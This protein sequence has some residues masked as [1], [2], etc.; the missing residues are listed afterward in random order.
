MSFHP[1]RKLKG[2]ADWDYFQLK[3]LK[4]RIKGG[5]KEF[6]F[7]RQAV[8]AWPGPCHSV[9]PAKQ[10]WKIP[11]SARCCTD[12]M[13]ILSQVQMITSPHRG[14]VLGMIILHTTQFPKCPIFMELTA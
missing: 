8:Q 10:D 7:Q 9:I 14:L 13:H 2:E 5:N 3:V 1:G 6:I 11:T 12:K 4:P